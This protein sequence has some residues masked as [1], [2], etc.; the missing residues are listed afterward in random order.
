MGLE[1]G[2]DGAVYDS[3]V[4]SPAFQAG[5]TSGMQVVGVN[6]RK[7]TPLDFKNALKATAQGQPMTLLYLNDDYYGTA[8]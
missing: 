8:H 4:G 7:F 6:G 5:I 2:R 1:L 3:I